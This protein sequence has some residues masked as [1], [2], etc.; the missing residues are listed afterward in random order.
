MTVSIASSRPSTRWAITS[1]RAT[2]YTA[3]IPSSTP[4]A[5]S[6]SRT[7]TARWATARTGVH[8][9]ASAKMRFDEA[10][11]QYEV[12]REVFFAAEHPC[13]Q[14]PHRD[15]QRR[16]AGVQLDRPTTTPAHGA[17]SPAGADLLRP[18]PHDFRCRADGPSPPW[19]TTPRH[20]HRN[21]SSYDG[22]D[23]RISVDRRAGQLRR[24]YVR[25][26]RQPGVRPTARKNAR[27]RGV[28]DHRDVLFGHVLR[29]P[30]PTGPPGRPRGR[31]QLQRQVMGLAAGRCLILGTV[32]LESSTSTLISC[33]GY[34]SRGNRVAHGRSQ[35]QFL[36]HGFR[37]GQPDHPDAAAP[38]A[39]R[40]RARIRRL[41]TTPSC[42]AA[43]PR[44]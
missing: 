36:G 18:H 14:R 7:V 13:L 30:E 32:Q 41:P 11:R 31:R 6:S 22:A 15:A 38:A 42:R 28:A 5:A 21:V 1:T 26:R 33:M 43:G 17:H 4:T 44:S 23:R 29:L 20:E 37:R 2:G 39:G 27:S 24:Q 9:L 3:A 10:G 8:L 19:P 34:D 12:Q 35:G 40:A 25:R 16:R